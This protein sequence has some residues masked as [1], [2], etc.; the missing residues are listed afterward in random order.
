M[1]NMTRHQ[2]LEEKREQAAE[3]QERWASL[4]PEQQLADL[5]RRAE[6]AEKQRKRIKKAIAEANAPKKGEKVEKTEGEKPKRK[7]K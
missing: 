1:A 7:V 2:R 3:R 4:T 6:R 5:D